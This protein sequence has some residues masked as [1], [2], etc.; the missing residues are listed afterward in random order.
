MGFGTK[1]RNRITARGG[2]S[3]GA[4]GNHIK[5]VKTGSLTFAAGTVTGGTIK[6]VAAALS[7]L[8]T[9]DLL[10][11]MGGAL[12]NGAVSN[13]L[14][15]AAAGTAQLNLVAPGTADVVVG[16]VT[17]RYLWIVF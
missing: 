16:N 17:Q 1:W 11:A 5:G 8:G 9:A 6:A 12:A 3:V 2:L 14:S 13:H 15:I 10:L 4:S 7:G